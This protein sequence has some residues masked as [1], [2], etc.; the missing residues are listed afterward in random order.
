MSVRRGA[1]HALVLGEEDEYNEGAA[2]PA[3]HMIPVASTNFGAYQGPTLDSPELTDDLNP[4]L[5]LDDLF[6][7][8][9][10]FNVAAELDVLG[11]LFHNMFTDYGVTGPVEGVYT[12][13][14]KPDAEDPASLWAEMAH[15][16]ETPAYDVLYGCYLSGFSLSL[17]KEGGLLQIPF[18][19][20]GSG[21]H[22]DDEAA[23]QDAAPTE[24]TGDRL[25]PRKTAVEIDGTPVPRVREIDFTVTRDM[26]GD[27]GLNAEDF[28]NELIF[29]GFTFEIGKLVGTWDDASELRALEDGD[30]HSVTIT[31]YE[32]A[33]TYVKFHFPE[34]L[35]PRTDKPSI[36][37]RGP[38]TYGFTGLKPGYNVAAEEAAIQI[39][40]VNATETYA[41][42]W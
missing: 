28:E 29:G 19:V 5:G 2:A 39:T 17:K 25:Q 32:T 33:T 23:P 31:V 40:I 22:D 42:S 21:K 1:S 20:L 30:T 34:V 16:L 35:F 8:D 38:I 24:Y 3:G 6:K 37:D 9:G 26:Q 7:A 36:G 15:N 10:S 27:E 41:S 14:Y 18:N 4:K 12:H 13:V 11:I